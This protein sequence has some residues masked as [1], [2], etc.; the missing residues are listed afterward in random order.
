MQAWCHCEDIFHIITQVFVWC[1]ITYGCPSLGL[2]RLWRKP[3]L[4]SVLPKHVGKNHMHRPKRAI[5][6]SWILSLQTYIFSWDG[7]F[8]SGSLEAEPEMDWFSEIYCVQGKGEK[9]SWWG[10]GLNKIWLQL[11]SSFCLIPMETSG[12]QPAH[13]VILP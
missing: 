2:H 10:K 1:S 8:R 5:S 11:E 9:Q 13:G 4:F 12:V 6:L 7:C 3:A